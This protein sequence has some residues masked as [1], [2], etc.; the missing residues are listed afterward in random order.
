[1]YI[2]PCTIRDGGRIAVVDFTRDVARGFYHASENDPF[3]LIRRRSF[4]VFGRELRDIN[5]E[6]FAVLPPRLR[7]EADKPAA[8]TRTVLDRVASELERAREPHMRD[9]VA[10]IVSDQY[11]M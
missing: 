10:S 2:G 5:D 3:G 8:S 7:G 9:I 4:D 11:R 1:M 6:V